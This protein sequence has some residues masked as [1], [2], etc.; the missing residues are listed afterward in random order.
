MKAS[1]ALGQHCLPLYHLQA[2]FQ[3]PVCLPY[4]ENLIASQNLSTASSCVQYHS[5]ITEK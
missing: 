4:F 2:L 3:N 5:G 1:R